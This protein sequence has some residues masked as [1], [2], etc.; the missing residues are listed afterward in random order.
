[1][2]KTLREVCSQEANYCFMDG[3]AYLSDGDTKEA[4]ACFAMAERH[5]QEANIPYTGK[6]KNLSWKD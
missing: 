6:G 5:L 3:Y 2:E 4:E 1:M